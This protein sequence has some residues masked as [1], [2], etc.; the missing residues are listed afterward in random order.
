MNIHEKAI[1]VLGRNH[2]RREDERFDTINYGRLHHD[3]EFLL[4]FP[5]CGCS[6]FGERTDERLP[7]RRIAS[8]GVPRRDP[9]WG[10]NC[11]L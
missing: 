9:I 3:A 1:L 4:H 6:L 8:I 5:S 2:L 11:R 10:S 7:T